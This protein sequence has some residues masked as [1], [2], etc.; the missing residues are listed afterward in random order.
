MVNGEK[1]ERK[2]NKSKSLCLAE[3]RERIKDVVIKRK[4]SPGFHR[5]GPLGER[6][7]S[8]HYSRYKTGNT[9]NKK[10]EEKKTLKNF[11]EPVSFVKLSGKR[12]YSLENKKTRRR[13][14]SRLSTAFLLS[15]ISLAAEREVKERE[16]EG[17]V[18]TR[19]RD[20]SCS[21]VIVY[22]GGHFSL[23]DIVVS[24]I[25]RQIDG[26]KNTE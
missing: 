24:V 19:E 8:S 4:F 17:G 23:R 25:D 10:G 3:G 14:V 22:L 6:P 9:Y 7:S 20:G 26:Y 12:Q 5:G 16:G 15:I 2:S 1:I 11:S 21:Y 18:R 13:K